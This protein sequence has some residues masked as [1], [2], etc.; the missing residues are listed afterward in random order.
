MPTKY[1]MIKMI[2]I[3]KLY[4][5]NLYLVKIIE[6]QKYEKEIIP[7]GV[8]FNEDDIITQNRLKMAQKMGTMNSNKFKKNKE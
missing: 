4:L 7:N 3:I 1:E 5:N 6:T 2:N 8:S